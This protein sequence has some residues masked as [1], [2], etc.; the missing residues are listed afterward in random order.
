MCAFSLPSAE[1]R[2]RLL[3]RMRDSE[4]VL[5]LGSGPDSVRFR[6]AL[7]ITVEELDEALASLDRVLRSVAR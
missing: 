3:T 5:L 6:P 1:L 7:T 2:D 4:R